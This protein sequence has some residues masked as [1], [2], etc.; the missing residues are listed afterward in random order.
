MRVAFGTRL[1]VLV[2]I[3]EL[4]DAALAE[5]VEALVDCVGVPEESSA[6]WA[7]QEGVQVPL[8]NPSDQLG[9]LR[10]YTLFSRW[11]FRWLGLR[12][13]LCVDTGLG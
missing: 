3:E 4:V 9:F 6:K 7:L 5:C 2:L 10:V 12:V 11:P 8:L 13:L 1:S